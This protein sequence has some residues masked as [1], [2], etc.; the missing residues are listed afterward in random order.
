MGLP[1]L[2]SWH[3]PTDTLTNGRPGILNQTIGSIVINETAVRDL[4][5][6]AP[7]VGKQLLWTMDKDTSYYVTVV[8]VMKDFHFTSMRNKIK[9]FAFVNSPATERGFTIKLSGDNLSGTIAQLQ[10]KWNAD[11]ESMEGAALHYVCGQLNIPY[12]QIRSISN[13]VGER[14]K[15]KWQFKKAIDHLNLE[16]DL[17]IAQLSI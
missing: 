4:A 13:V 2:P 14:D 9:P 1:I 10:N 17:I 11:I 5:I 15:T 6:T 16:L 7:V 3:S 8:G 12:L